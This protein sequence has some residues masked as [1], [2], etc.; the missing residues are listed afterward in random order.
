MEAAGEFRIT[1]DLVLRVRESAHK[2]G[3]SVEDISHAVDMA[4]VEIELDPGHEPAKLLI[5]GPDPA[6]NLLELVGGEFGDDL[7]IWH[8]DRCRPAYQKLLP[9]A[10]GGP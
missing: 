8:A 10:G 9:D 1:L 2:H 7:W 5:I 3:C 4:L 6:A